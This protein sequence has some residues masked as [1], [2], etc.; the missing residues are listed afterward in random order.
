MQ[1]KNSTTKRHILR[2]TLLVLLA[3]LIIF[4]VFELWISKHWLQVSHYEISSD[5]L[6]HDFRIVQLTDLHNSVFG[7]NNEKLAGK[8]AAEKPDLILITGDLLNQGDENTDIATGLIS[9]MTKI[10]PVYVSFGNHEVGYEERWGADLT[11]LYKEAGAADVIDRSWIEVTV[12]G[13]LIRLGGI[14]GYCLPEKTA[15]A[16]PDRHEESEFVK[17]FEDTDDYCVL[18]A[19]MPVCWMING[20]LDAYDV[21]CV[22]SGHAHGGQIVIPFA[23]GFY[24][25]DQGHFIGR[26]WGVFDSKDGDKHLV[27]SRGLGSNEKIPRFNNRPEILVV[28]FKAKQE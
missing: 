16:R 13:Q 14:Y 5:R 22:I 10:A 23:G 1:N 12:N 9:R 15:K 26:E 27:L 20:S 4:C 6:D 21:D 19:H 2:N 18:M 7:K 28:D 24:A 8:V 17:R 11:A 3:V 25:P